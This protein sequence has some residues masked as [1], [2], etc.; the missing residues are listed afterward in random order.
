ML[1]RNQCEAFELMLTKEIAQRHALGAYSTD[2]PTILTL[3]QINFELLRHIRE[4]EERRKPQP[5]SKE[6]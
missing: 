3:C 4:T 1:S 2:A 5:K 6:K